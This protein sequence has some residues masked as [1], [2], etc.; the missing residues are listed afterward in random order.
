MKPPGTGISLN[1]LTASYTAPVSQRL[2]RMPP[3]IFV[4]PTAENSPPRPSR[5]KSFSAFL[6]PFSSTSSSSASASGPTPLVP[7][8]APSST[9]T[10]TASSSPHSAPTPS[11]PLPYHSAKTGISLTD[12]GHIALGGSPFRVY[13]QNSP[14]DGLPSTGLHST[15]HERRLSAAPDA[16]ARG[17]SGLPHSGHP[18]A[19]LT[20]SSYSSA[21]DGEVRSDA[22]RTTCKEMPTLASAIH[23]ADAL[24]GSVGGGKKVKR[25]QAGIIASSATSSS[26]TTGAAAP[27][28]AAPSK[29][30]R[31]PSQTELPS[32][33][34]RLPRSVS[35]SSSIFDAYRNRK[36]L[37]RSSSRSSTKD[38]A[39][40]HE[41][42]ARGD[43]DS[44]S[45]VSGTVRPRRM[46]RRL[47]FDSIRHPFAGHSRRKDK[48]SG[49]SI[50]LTAPQRPMAASDNATGTAGQPAK[51][52][53]SIGRQ[54]RLALPPMRS[55]RNKFSVG[56]TKA[57]SS[58][59]VAKADVA[60]RRR[61][62]HVWDEVNVVRRASSGTKPCEGSMSLGSAAGRGVLRRMEAVCA[63]PCKAL[64]GMDSG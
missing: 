29:L 35:S 48:D 41:V 19:D 10:T 31:K 2:L 53:G 64:Q 11:A 54:H 25:D 28:S 37:R 18:L 47:S 51:E 7:L 15:P 45:S 3:A 62:V 5:F 46:S 36:S 26:L 55:L 17:V 32:D 1:P 40:G 20:R 56:N 42:G 4:K 24:D 16:A 39:C 61:N 50:D 44:S 49:S 13:L 27:A 63:H 8:I 12:L 23:I 52:Q 33:R 38:V 60:A 43:A 14:A 21:D 6:N 34:G 57:G 30:G 22:L 59:A 58:L 9:H